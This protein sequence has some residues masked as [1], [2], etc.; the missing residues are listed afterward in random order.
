MFGP[1]MVLLI[2]SH[3]RDAIACRDICGYDFIVDCPKDFIPNF[4]YYHYNTDLFR[5]FLFKERPLDKP[6]KL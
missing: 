5:H 3:S 6:I 1:L 2:P 4:N